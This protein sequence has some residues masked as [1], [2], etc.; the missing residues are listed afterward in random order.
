[1]ATPISHFWL[2]RYRNV[3]IHEHFQTTT[4]VSNVYINMKFVHFQKN[5]K[6]VHFHTVPKMIKIAHVCEE[7]YA[8]L[9]CGAKS[10]IGAPKGIN[11]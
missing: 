2:S 11:W 3:C 9:Q 1:M 6:P 8:R 7:D 4:M 5:S 10:S